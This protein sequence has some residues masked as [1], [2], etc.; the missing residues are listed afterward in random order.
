MSSFILLHSCSF[1]ANRMSFYME[2]TPAGTS[3]Q[4]MLHWTQ[5]ITEAQFQMF[6][7]MNENWNHYNSSRPPLYYPSK[8]SIPPVAFYSGAKDILADPLDVQHLYEVLPDSNKPI[9]HRIEPTYNH[10]DFV[11]GINAYQLIYPE[12]VQL[13]KKYS[14]LLE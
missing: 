9:I 12:I 1:C 5:Q 4:N 2:H 7:W 14:N 8:M 10:L 3:V 11:W 6:D 13:A